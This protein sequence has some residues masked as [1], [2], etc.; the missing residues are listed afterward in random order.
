MGHLA[1]VLALLALASAALP[2]NF[3]YVGLGCG[4]AATGVGIVAYRNKQSPARSRL[5]GA[6]GLTAGAVAGLLGA[7]R[8]VLT[9]LAIDHFES[10]LR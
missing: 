2:G 3:M 9:V 6:F 7:A 5:L 1:T 10:M 8:I 4:L